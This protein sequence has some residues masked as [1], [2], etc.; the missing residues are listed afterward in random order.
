[1][2]RSDDL[3]KAK[4]E[5]NDEFYTQLEDIEKEMSH[6]TEQFKDKVV[7]CKCD[8]PEQ[9][10][11]WKYFYDN[12]HSLGLKELV[13]TYYDIETAVYKTTYDGNDVVK[14]ALQCN[15][16]FRSQ[17]CIDVLDECDIVVTKPPFSLFR[18]FV[19]TLI[20]HDKQFLII[21]NVNSIIC[22]ELVPLIVENKMWLGASI[23]SGDRKFNVP[24]YY[25]LE[26]AGCGI[27]SDGRK[28]IRV[29]GVRWFTN[30][31]Y[32]ARHEELVLSKMYSPEEYPTY[33]GYNAINVNKT[34]DIP[35]DYD[36]EM[37]VPITFIDKYNPDQFEIIN[38]DRYINGYDTHSDK[39]FTVN[40]KRLYRRI[41]IKRK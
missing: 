19:A 34:K 35:M 4:A 28:F 23:H 10:M 20:E 5:K 27:D 2:S 29:K 7:Y 41:I 38:L 13:S 22:K 18:E 16:D 15:G 9:S 25:P 31:D 1:M 3:K 32:L 14:S 40:G 8:K 37:G 6:Y 21:G 36:G 39:L 30:L 33:D 17:E 24:D 26:A 12:F 11:F